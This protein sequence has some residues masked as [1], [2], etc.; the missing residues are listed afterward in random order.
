MRLIK[1]LLVTRRRICGAISGIRAAPV[2]VRA[3]FCGSRA[4][5]AFARRDVSPLMDSGIAPALDAEPTLRISGAGAALK[6]KEKTM[7]VRQSSSL[8]PAR[9]CSLIAACVLV[10]AATAVVARAA[11]GACCDKSDGSC[12]EGASDA[13]TGVDESYQG[14]GST[15][16]THCPE[17]TGTQ[18]TFQGALST[19]NGPVGGKVDLAVSLWDAPID[20]IQVAST[21]E[22]NDV[23]LDTGG[24]QGLFTLQLDFGG[25]VFNGDPR[26][27]QI[28]VRKPPAGFETISPR[29]P[30]RAV[31]YAIQTRG[32]FVT[33]DAGEFYVGIGTTSPVSPLKVEADSAN[34]AVVWAHNTST[35]GLL[36]NGVRAE[37]DSPSGRGL[38]ALAGASNGA[39]HAVWAQTESP[40]GYAGYFTGPAGSKNYFEQ[41]VGVGTTDPLTTLHVQSSALAA[42]I[43]PLEADDLAHDDIVVEDTD[44]VLGLYSNSGGLGAS[45]IHL[46]RFKD[47]EMKE[48]WT[49][50]HRVAGALRFNHWDPVNGTEEVLRLQGNGTTRVK[51]LEIVGADVAERFP[52][53]E[54]LEPGMVVA[55]DPDNP[56][57]LCLAR[58]AYNRGVAGVVSGANSFSAGAVLGNLPGHEDA[59]PIALSGRVYVWCDATEHAIRP[60]DLLTSSDTPG[61]AMKVIDHATAQGAV[62]GKAM[63]GLAKG[64]KGL[65]LVL[66]NLQ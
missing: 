24:G 12:T 9:T 7:M 4:T 44:A 15:C 10:T 50:L 36:Q 59:P 28:A 58:G 30:I 3:P 51:V 26:W 66:V 2:R 17:P 43:G 40:D 46:G 52:A 18:F 60:T 32:L 25:D 38:F 48:K 29:Q 6:Y 1:S 33:Q 55:I 49:I 27:V 53:S 57:K 56:G 37:T 35:S 47:G 14:D 61:H 63:S 65:V 13:C 62:L 54:E 23:D 39:N 42:P 8:L 16:A 45:R 64:E 20:G 31:P 21:V 41:R 11:S 5:G 34:F 22:F 19:G